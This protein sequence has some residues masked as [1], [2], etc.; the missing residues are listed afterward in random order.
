MCIRDRYKYSSFPFPL[1]Y[2]YTP[3]TTSGIRPFSTWTWV[4][5]SSDMVFFLH[6]FQ[7]WTSRDKWNRFLWLGCLSCHIRQSTAGR[8]KYWPP[9]SGLAS[10]FLHPLPGSWW[11]QPCSLY[12]SSSRLL[13]L[14]YAYT[15]LNKAAKLLWCNAASLI[16]VHGQVT[17]IF[18]VSVCLSVCLFVCAEFFSAVFDPISIKLGHMLYD[19]V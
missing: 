18:V 5:A 9:T 13:P 15:A 1:L 16:L 2:S 19:W 3:T 14:C 7:K 8:T 11:K 4:R 10:S 6:V 17:I 12:Q